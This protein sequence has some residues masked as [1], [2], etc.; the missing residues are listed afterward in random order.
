MVA[1]W[2]VRAMLN[3]QLLSQVSLLADI[4]WILPYIFLHLP[5]T[6]ITCLHKFSPYSFSFFEE[7]CVK[8]AHTQRD[9]DDDGSVVF[10]AVRF[11]LS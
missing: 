3:K 4:I 5:S 7:R 1:G 2:L 10:A 6:Y 8:V 9:D 11:C